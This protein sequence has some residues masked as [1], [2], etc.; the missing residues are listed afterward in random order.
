MAT[1]RGNP[2]QYLQKVGGTYYARVR[3]PRTLEKYTGQTHIRRTLETGDRAEANRRK[4]AVVGTIKADLERLRKAPTGPLERGISFAD[5]KLWREDLKAAELAD[6]EG[7]RHDIIHDAAINKAEELERLYGTDKAKRWFKAATTTTDT[8]PE[9]MGQWLDASDYKAS[10]NAGHRKALAEV[11]KFVGNDHAV[12]ADVTRKVAMSFID[13]DLTER[14]PALAHSTIRDRLVSLGGFWKWMSSRDAVASNV[15]PWSDHKVSKERN[16]GRSPPKRKGGYT[17]DEIVKLLVGNDRVK[18]WPTYS[19]MPDLMVLGLFTGAREESLCALRVGDV[20]KGRGNCILRI[21]ND[22]NVSGDRPVGIT[23]AAALAVLKRRMHGRHGQDLLF[24]ELKPG[25]L[26]AKLSSSA[27]KAYGRYRRACGVPD[28]TDF[29]SYRRNVCTVLE[30]A[31]V[32]QVP[33]A[34]FVGQ[35]VGTMAA[36]TY[37][38]G[39]AD[40]NSLMTSRKVRYGAGVEAAAIELVSMQN[41]PYRNA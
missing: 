14:D 27:V 15:N 12:P 25:G 7:E 33:I 41:A 34:R 39:S 8:L 1:K 37:S 6:D 13:T 4:H 28:G 30:N 32:G 23:H 31:G 26:D 10:T 9:L 2:D 22:K 29:H 20:E 18:A 36:D 35:K 38:G 5:A 19:Y 24:P 40:A 11:L 17:A 21:T 3:V 16:K